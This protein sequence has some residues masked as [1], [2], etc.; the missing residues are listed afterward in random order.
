MKVMEKNDVENV[1]F[2][3]FHCTGKNSNKNYIKQIKDILSR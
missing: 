2:F 3:N 1:H